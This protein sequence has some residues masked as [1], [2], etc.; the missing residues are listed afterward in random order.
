MANEGTTQVERHRIYSVYIQYIGDFVILI[1]RRI[2][3]VDWRPTT[4][5]WPRAVPTVGRGGHRA[6]T[7]ARRIVRVGPKHGPCPNTR[8]GAA[9]CR[10]GGPG[11]GWA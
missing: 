8:T 11:L 1:I 4:R 5:C 9:G 7:R 6:R 2:D 3:Y 10:D